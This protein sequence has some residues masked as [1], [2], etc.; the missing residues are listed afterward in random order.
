VTFV[1]HWNV[2]RSKQWR[3]FNDAFKSES[4]PPNTYILPL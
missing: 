3:A 4:N 2:D 1:I